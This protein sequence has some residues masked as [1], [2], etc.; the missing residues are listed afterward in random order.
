V[1][2]QLRHREAELGLAILAEVLDVVINE[3]DIRTLNGSRPTR[4]FSK[5]RRS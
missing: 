2:V 3:E 1:N 5:R 4:P